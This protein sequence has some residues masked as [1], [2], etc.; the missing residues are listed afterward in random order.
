MKKEK[1]CHQC[2]ALKKGKYCHECGTGQEVTEDRIDST[3]CYLCDKKLTGFWIA[4]LSLF[5]K[6]KFK[7][8]FILKQ[9]ES[10]PRFCGLTCKYKWIKDNLHDTSSSITSKEMPAIEVIGRVIIFLICMVGFLILAY[11]FFVFMGFANNFLSIL[12][13][14]Q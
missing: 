10:Y 12:Q 14:I 1:Y 8:K 13:S 11:E 5:E 9:G 2:G 3:K 7:S 4:D 6:M